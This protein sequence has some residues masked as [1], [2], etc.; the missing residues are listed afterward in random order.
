MCLK[1]LDRMHLTKEADLKI[2]T[3]KSEQRYLNVRRKRDWKEQ[4]TRWKFA[5][6]KV[7]LGECARFWIELKRILF[8]SN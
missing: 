8:N 2:V 1:C 6:A 5:T 3:S 4:F 7:W